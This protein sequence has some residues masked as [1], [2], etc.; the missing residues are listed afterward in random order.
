M[1]GEG[2]TRV[3]HSQKLR[4]FR[5]NRV[6]HRNAASGNHFGIDPALVMAEPVHQ[7]LRDGEVARAGVGIDIDG[8]AA[9]DPFTT[10]TLI[11]PIASV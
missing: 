9:G 1:K 10:C 3:P 4:L 7:C 11:S 5:R 8:G 6:A 2:R